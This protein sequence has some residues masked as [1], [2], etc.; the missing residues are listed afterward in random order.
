MLNSLRDFTD[1]A[2]EGYAHIQSTTDQFIKKKMESEGGKTTL[3][4]IA[5][6]AAVY[7]L[8]KIAPGNLMLRFVSS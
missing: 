6:N 2:V 8:W 1:R 5:A 3:I 7:V 4:L